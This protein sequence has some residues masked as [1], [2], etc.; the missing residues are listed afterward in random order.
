M[1]QQRYEEAREILQKA[2]DTASRLPEEVAGQLTEQVETAE[3]EMTKRQ[4]REL[5]EAYLKESLIP[6]QGLADLGPKEGWMYSHADTWFSRME[7]S[8]R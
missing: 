5:F 4:E 2:E 1:Q 8:V 6:E 7:S 3:K